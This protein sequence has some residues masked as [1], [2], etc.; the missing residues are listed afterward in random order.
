MYYCLIFLFLLLWELDV[1]HGDSLIA[2]LEVRKKFNLNFCFRVMKS[3]LNI[4]Q[5]H[6]RQNKHENK[7]KNSCDS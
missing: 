6:T 4:V 3:I 2:A 5:F 7:T 1:D